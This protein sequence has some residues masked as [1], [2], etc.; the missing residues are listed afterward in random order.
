MNFSDYEVAA[1]SSYDI[2][3]A[4]GIINTIQVLDCF[5]WGALAV[6]MFRYSP[7]G[8]FVAANLQIVT[9]GF[10][11]L[12][13]VAPNSRALISLTIWCV[14]FLNLMMFIIGLMCGDKD[15]KGVTYTAAWIVGTYSLLFLMTVAAQWL[16]VDVDVGAP[17]TSLDEVVSVAEPCLSALF[18]VFFF[19]LHGSRLITFVCRQQTWLYESDLLVINLGFFAIVLC[20][21]VTYNKVLHSGWDPVVAAASHLGR[22]LFTQLCFG[23]LGRRRSQLPTLLSGHETQKP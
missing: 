12:R 4:F 1:T 22:V 2:T 21:K 8:A 5:A 6:K 16:T 23:W 9:P 19:F 3:S 20:E 15:P 11:A 18:I 7:V 14:F 13:N 10:Y 17:A